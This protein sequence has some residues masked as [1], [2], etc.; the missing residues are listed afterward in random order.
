MCERVEPLAEQAR[1]A[2]RLYVNRQDSSSRTVREVRF[3][4]VGGAGAGWPSAV[5]KLAASTQ[6]VLK[7]CQSEYS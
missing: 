4:L 2:H 6:V 5:V 3:E 7:R 1:G